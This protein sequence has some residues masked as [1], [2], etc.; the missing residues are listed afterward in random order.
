MAD[1]PKI[2]SKDDEHVSPQAQEPTILIIDDDEALLNMAVEV[3]SN[4]GRHSVIK[5]SDPDQALQLI[6]TT[7]SLKLL[8]SDVELGST[9]GPALIREALKDRP[10]SLGVVF[11]SG[12]FDAAQFRK[13]DP[14]LQKPV[15]INQLRAV[16]GEVLNSRRPHFEPR[17]DGVERR[18]SVV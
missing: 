7:P 6:A 14:K 4:S 3:L 2:G 8:L 16:V 17:K 10:P 11:M 15:D 18:R 1:D 13:T 5:A 12:N 9:T